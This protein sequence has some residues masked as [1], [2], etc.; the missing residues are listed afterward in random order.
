MYLDRNPYYEKRMVLERT[1][2]L[3]EK[4]E[5]D[6]K[7][8]KQ[9]IVPDAVDK[10]KQETEKKKDDGPGFGKFN[11]KEEEKKKSVPEKKAKEEEVPKEKKKEV[12]N[13]DGNKPTEE[14]KEETPV[15]PGKIPIKL[16][17][18]TGIK[19]PPK[20]V[21]PPWTPVTRKIPQKKSKDDS[22]SKKV[23]KPQVEKPPS[24]DTFLIVGSAT[25]EGKLPVVNMTDVDTIPL[26]SA[27]QS[28]DKSLIDDAFSGRFPENVTKEQSEELKYLGIEMSQEQTVMPKPPPPPSQNLS[29]PPERSDSMA[30][31]SA[32]T[33]YNIFYTNVKAEKTDDGNVQEG[34]I[35]L[36]EVLPEESASANNG[37]MVSSADAST[38]NT[39]ETS[40]RHSSADVEGAVGSAAETCTGL[41]SKENNDDLCKSAVAVDIVQISGSSDGQSS[42]E[43][44]NNSLSQSSVDDVASMEGH[45]ENNPEPG[46]TMNQPQVDNAESSSGKQASVV[47]VA[48][49]LNGNSNA[50]E[51]QMENNPEPG[52]T[53][54]QP[55]V[56]NAESSSDK[57]ASVVYVAENLN[58]NSNA[59]EGHMEN[60]PEPGSTMNQPQVDNAE[61][62][63][64]KQASVVYVAE[65]LNGNSNAV[66]GHMENNPEPGST[67]NQPQVDNAESSSDKQASVVYVAENLNRNSNAVEGAMEYVCESNMPT[68]VVSPVPESDRP[69]IFHGGTVSSTTISEM[70]TSAVISSVAEHFTSVVQSSTDDETN[71]IVTSPA[72]QQSDNDANNSVQSFLDGSGA[73]QSEPSGSVHHGGQDVSPRA[74]DERRAD[75]TSDGKGL[76]P[77][78]L[79]VPDTM[80]TSEAENTR[81]ET[82]VGP[83]VVSCPVVHNKINADTTSTGGQ[84]MGHM[85]S[86]GNSQIGSVIILMEDE[87]NESSASDDTGSESKA[88]TTSNVKQFQPSNQENVA[89][90]EVDVE[91][92]TPE[93]PELI[94]NMVVD[95]DTGRNAVSTSDVCIVNPQH[96]T[97]VCTTA[98][99]EDPA[100]QRMELENTVGT[101]SKMTRRMV[102]VDKTECTEAVGIS[103]EPQDTIED[104]ASDEY[105]VDQTQSD[106]E[107]SMAADPE[108]VY[109]GVDEAAS[110]D[111][112]SSTQTY[113][114]DPFIGSQTDSKDMDVEL[115]GASTCTSST[116][117]WTDVV[118]DAFAAIA[119]LAESTSEVS[120]FSPNNS[121][122]FT[123]AAGGS[124]E[125][126]MAQSSTEALLSD[127][128]MSET[129]INP[130]AIQIEG[131]PLFEPTEVVHSTTQSNRDFALAEKQ[132]VGTS[133]ETVSSN[134]LVDSTEV[135]SD[136]SA[137]INI[138]QTNEV[139][140]GVDVC[141]EY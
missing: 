128:A 37:Q 12:K 78:V 72:A 73:L 51:G 121:D 7:Q 41:P 27:L 13:K 18:K 129:F 77:V 76:M 53:M 89:T 60:N 99:D 82:D 38:T 56:D 135:E 48:E 45:M 10:V 126:T 17:G 116:N 11:H 50:V 4:K 35:A 68:F 140:S 136:E 5:D 85:G 123:F 133:S 43:N 59:V 61:S 66:E 88:D 96:A 33:M 2:C 49:N 3:L 124:Q 131:I 81:L 80:R 120:I 114:E 75:T 130:E 32:K 58:R 31:S 138:S 1:A 57:Q 64:D 119:T 110:S 97:Y 25:T 52:S 100:D 62:S 23:I 36:K 54:N 101:S 115:S 79:Y 39:N 86:A 9:E 71:I 84:F 106:D 109:V 30:T 103:L 26:P 107:S 42:H 113:F 93:T 137:E 118:N 91:V 105:M 132:L 44:K 92:T 8:K 6:E 28:V 24:L 15:E 19:P 104:D 47:Y 14:K 65:N 70:V 63:S 117:N 40:P 94:V 127:Q 21:L 34:E 83:D 122:N 102:Q 134:V 141:G 69:A 22:S 87:S 125:S 108:S 74:F 16:T 67:M 98:G 111:V 139:E 95:T 46:C 112:Q 29:L 20:K 90:S 55:Q